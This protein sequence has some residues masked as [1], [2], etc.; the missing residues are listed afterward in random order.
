MGNG[1]VIFDKEPKTWNDLQSLVAKA[2]QEMGCEASIEKPIMGVRGTTAIDVYVQDTTREPAIITLCECKHWSKKVPKTVVHAFRTV[3]SD[4][5]SHVGILIS[6]VGFQS[7]AYRAAESSNI[8]LYNWLEFQKAYET[9]WTNSIAVQ[10]RRLGWR[11]NCY[12]FNPLRPKTRKEDYYLELKKLNIA[13]G[14]LRST[15]VLRAED[16]MKSRFPVCILNPDVGIDDFDGEEWVDIHSKREYVDLYLPRL[17]K[18]LEHLQNLY[19]PHPDFGKEEF[20]IR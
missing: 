11:I 5:G 8:H 10:I 7:G 14:C 19:G 16:I 1:A 15:A 2:F 17:K 13:S 3:V 18:C 12:F 20:Y 9:R 4:N 6:K